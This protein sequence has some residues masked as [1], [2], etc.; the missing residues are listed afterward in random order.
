MPDTLGHTCLFLS[1]TM[2]KRPCILESV[3]SQI[4]SPTSVHV[5][6]ILSGPDITEDFLPFSWGRSWGQILA[7]FPIE[8]SNL[9]PNTTSVFLNKKRNSFY[10]F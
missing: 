6:S 3:M 8:N 2:T 10:F 1:F 9:F 5:I 7:P 4:D